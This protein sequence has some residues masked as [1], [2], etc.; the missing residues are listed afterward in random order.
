MNL[1]SI[2][3]DPINSI[4]IIQDQSLY[5]LSYYGTYGC[6]KTNPNLNMYNNAV[7]II[8]DLSNPNSN[9]VSFLRLYSRDKITCD[10]CYMNDILYDDIKI[11]I[12]FFTINKTPSSEHNYL[13][14]F[15]KQIFP[16]FLEE[17]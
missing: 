16:Q 10:L 13:F 7:W 6:T 5:F 11:H 12:T 9:P 14:Q 15:I 3:N 2:F 8:T 1:I 17:A 4:N